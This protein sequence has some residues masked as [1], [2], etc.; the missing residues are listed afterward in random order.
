M[1]APSVEFEGRIWTKDQ[2]ADWTSPDPY[3]SAKPPRVD[4]LNHFACKLMDEIYLLRQGCEFAVKRERDACERICSN[5]CHPPDAP[6]TIYHDGWND[7]SH[8]CSVLIRNRSK[9]PEAVP[10]GQPDPRD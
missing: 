4:R 3:S 10:Q 9:K 2:A 1:E 7:G 6:R 8:T 5:N